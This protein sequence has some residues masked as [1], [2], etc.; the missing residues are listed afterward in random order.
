MEW[1]PT[2]PRCAS[3]Y[4]EIH[5]VV[6]ATGS[7]AGVPCDNDWHKGPGYDPSKLNLSDTDRAFLMETHIRCY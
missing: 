1:P 3:K 4:A 2:C 5:G 6:F 7:T